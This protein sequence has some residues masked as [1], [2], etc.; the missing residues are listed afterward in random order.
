MTV[1]HTLSHYAITKMN[2]TFASLLLTYALISSIKNTLTVS[3]LEEL[4]I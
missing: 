2:K 3:Q 4:R 1:C